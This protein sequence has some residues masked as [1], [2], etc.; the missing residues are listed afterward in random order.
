[1]EPSDT[2]RRIKL[3]DPA[4][5]PEHLQRV[6]SR[7]WSLLTSERPRQRAAAI[8]SRAPLA[9]RRRLLQLAQQGATPAQRIFWLRAEADLVVQAAAAVAP[10]VKGCAHCCHMPVLA[11]EAEAK[12]IGRAI[13]RVPVS[14]EQ[15]AA[16]P[17][18]ESREIPQSELSRHYGVACPFLGTDGAC[19]IYESRPLVCRHHIA[20]DDDD[21]LCQL[22]VSVEIRQPNLGR[23]SARNVYFQAMGSGAMVADIRQW[24]PEPPPR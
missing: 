23:L 16:V 12:I 5:N 20:L 9:S 1:M 19:T 22:M 2:P 17:L 6:K 13:G 8:F 18:A 3:I 10:C 11:A 4:E 21:L 24:F 14:A 7:H 15:A